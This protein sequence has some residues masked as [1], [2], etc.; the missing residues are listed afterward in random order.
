[1]SELPD[2]SWLLQVKDGALWPVKLFAKGPPFSL[3]EN[4][5]R[6]GQSAVDGATELIAR[7]MA[8]G[9]ET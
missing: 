9:S 3:S 6:S 7:R 2:D 5:A 4:P 1:M 8:S